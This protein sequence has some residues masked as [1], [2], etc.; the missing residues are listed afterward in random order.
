MN[1]KL[2][3]VVINDNIVRVNNIVSVTIINNSTIKYTS[4]NYRLCICHTR[5]NNI[6]SYLGTGTSLTDNII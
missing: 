4:I 2:L 6:I 1:Y 3:N 5:G